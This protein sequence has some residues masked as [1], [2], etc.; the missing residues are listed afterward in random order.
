MPELKL[1]YQGPLYNPWYDWANRYA[2]SYAFLLGS[3][4]GYY[5]SDEARFTRE[6][7]RRL[8]IV[9]DGIFG[10]RT[11]AAA[12]YAWPGTSFPPVVEQRR[13]I[14]YYSAPG[15]GVPWWVGPGYD[16]GEMLAGKAFNGPG[17]QSL[18]IN[19][20]PVGFPIGGY[21]GLLGGDPGLSY[22][23]VIAA[24]GAELERLLWDNP[25]V[26]RAMA[27]RQADPKAAVDVELWLEGYSQSA[28][29][30][31]EAV[32]RLFGDGGPFEIIR[33]R[34][35][36]LL[37]YGDPATPV[38]GIARKTFPAWLEKLVH[39]IN[40]SHDFYAV[41][42]DRV[43]PLFYEWFIQAET[44]LPFVVYSAQII[45]PAIA[46][47]I[48]LLGPVLGPLFPVALALQTGM[49][50]AI[51]LLTQITA[52]VNS[53]TTKPNPELIK[54]LSAQGLL[55]SVPDLLTLVTS[56]PGLQEHWNYHLPVADF[57]GLTGPQRA[58]DLV[59][60]FRR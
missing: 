42:K 53:A 20:Q 59:A 32:K 15:S 33:D 8:G 45:L 22:L 17:R 21:L 6:L 16:L 49:Q 10:D 12:G 56:L 24:Q 48:P 26:K 46:N 31:R 40:T 55:T 50:S 18:R 43:R 52:G 19:H 44:D 47:A 25:D 13:P 3:R 5:G 11:A 27:A 4:D 58:Y 37:L 2:K 9:Q 39:E 60:A 23:E 36:G 57:G 54:L 35:N 38:T 1:G 30:L 29:G 34:I 41:A 28:D 51:P 14:W 7:Q